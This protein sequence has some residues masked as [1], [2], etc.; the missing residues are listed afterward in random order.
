MVWTLFFERFS[1]LDPHH[2][3]I[4]LHFIDTLTYKYGCV[5]ASITLS[6]QSITHVQCSH[7]LVLFRWINS[8][9]E[10]IQRIVYIGHLYQC[11]FPYAHTKNRYKSINIKIQAK[12]YLLFLIFSLSLTHTAVVGIGVVGHCF[13]FDFQFSKTHQKLILMDNIEH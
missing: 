10:W 4:H 12:T 6:H 8:Y 5:Y 3:V 11:H 2:P 13:C 1:I 7:I 9:F